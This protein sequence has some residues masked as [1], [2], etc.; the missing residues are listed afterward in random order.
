MKTIY[1]HDRLIARFATSNTDV[2]VFFEKSSEC[3]CTERLR[4]PASYL[5]ALQ[6][7]Y[8]HRQSCVNENVRRLRLAESVGFTPAYKLLNHGRQFF[9]VFLPLIARSWR[10]SV[11]VLFEES[12]QCRGGDGVRR[13]MAYL[14]VL[15]SPELHGKSRVCQ[16]TYCL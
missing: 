3:S 2:R 16:D 8:A 13:S 14:P 15:Q 1:D 4:G 11:R 7:P 12:R 6:G 5:P 10:A 9:R